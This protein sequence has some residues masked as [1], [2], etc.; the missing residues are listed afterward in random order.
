MNKELLR[1]IEILK[2]VPEIKELIEIIK[3]WCIINHYSILHS[4][5]LWY[6]ELTQALINWH[7][8]IRF[9]DELKKMV[10]DNNIDSTFKIIWQIH[11]WHLRMFLEEKEIYAYIEWWWLILVNA[12]PSRPITSLD[13]TKPYQ[14]QSEEFFKKLNDWL[15]KEFNIK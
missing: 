2:T 12:W 6:V 13:N 3:K 11:E 9:D 4:E 7:W 10:I 5:D 14:E 15:I 1:H 8:S